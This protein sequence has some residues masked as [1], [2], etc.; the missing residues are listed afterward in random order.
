VTPVVS[1]S[2]LRSGI[3]G[4]A[5]YQGMPRSSETHLVDLAALIARRER[6]ADQMQLRL[7]QLGQQIAGHAGALLP[8]GPALA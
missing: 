5:D 1:A 7:A 8:P 4:G 3:A 2:R 6:E